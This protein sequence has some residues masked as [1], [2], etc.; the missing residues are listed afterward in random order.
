MMNSVLIYD[1]DI[2]SQLKTLVDLATIVWKSNM[3][4]VGL[5]AQMQASKNRP[6][7]RFTWFQEPVKFE[8]ALGR[9]FPI[10]SEYNGRVRHRIMPTQQL[11]IADCQ[12]F[13]KVEAIMLDQFRDGIGY[14]KVSTGNYEL[15]NS[16]D[17]SQI[18][19]L[20]EDECLTPGL[21]ITMAMIVFQF[22]F[23]ISK[24]CPKRDCRSSKVAPNDAGGMTW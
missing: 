1:R 8:D 20:S 19:T 6:E 21:A 9:I 12:C 22:G 3:Q 15:F 23:A 14:Q 10:P 24:R 16:L 18:V 17:S 13:Q 7:L 11:S 2:S 4:L 5:I